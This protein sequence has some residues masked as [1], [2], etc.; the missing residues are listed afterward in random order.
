MKETLPHGLDWIVAFADTHGKPMSVPEWGVGW[1]KPQWVELIANWIK[2]IN[3]VYQTY[4]DNNLDPTH[5]TRISDGSKGLAGHAYLMHFGSEVPAYGASAIAGAVPGELGAGGSMP[6]GWGQN[7]SNVTVT[8]LG[9]DV[10]DGVTCVRVRVAAN[11]TGEDFSRF[12]SFFAPVNWPGAGPAAQGEQWRASAAIRL[13]D[14][15][16]PGAVLFSAEM[17]EVDGS[18]GWLGNDGTYDGP[19][20]FEAFPL[21]AD[22]H[23]HVRKLTEADV[24]TVAG[25][26]GVYLDA[27]SIPSTADVL[28][29]APVLVREQ[30]GA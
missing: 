15:N 25:V 2:S 5:Q 9:T 12:V 27:S 4:F 23:T 22:Y 7:L 21:Y 8:V 30:S 26:I 11:G 10:V 16:G 20:R 18:G 13:E 6:T 1:D 28:I 17:H 29:A 14:A 19:D 24:E 3:P